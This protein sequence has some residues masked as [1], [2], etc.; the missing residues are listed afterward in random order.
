M[1]YCNEC[2]AYIPDG[3]SKCLACGYDETES[4]KKAAEEK[5]GAQAYDYKYE[6]PRRVDNDFLK[7]QL[8]EQRR[9]QQEDSRKWAEA[10]QAQR[11]KAQQEQE[12]Y[13]YSA[14]T[15]SRSTDA[16]KYSAPV[17]ITSS[18][19][20]AALSYFGILFVVP[21]IL[22]KEDSFAIFH[23]KQGLILFVAGIV[24]KIA[25]SIFGLGW[26]VTLARLYFIYKGVSNVLNGKKEALPYIGTLI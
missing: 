12:K 20:F 22:C 26:I 17:S 19:V 18:K 11:R 3:H 7:K 9:R 14:G 1:A 8:D 16:K 10:E 5:A 15:A 2:G 24:A 6:E 23:A 13:S 25:A 21:Y 4:V